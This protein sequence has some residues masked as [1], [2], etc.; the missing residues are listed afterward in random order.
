MSAPT[1]MGST[2]NIRIFQTA[3]H[4]CGYYPD[5]L[6]RDLVL[7][8]AD[9]ALAGIYG[10]ALAM[11]FRRSGAHVYRPACLGCSACRPVRIPVARFIPDRSQRRCLKR[12]SDLQLSVQPAA[13]SEENFALYRRYL[14]SRHAGGGMDQPQASDFDAFLA[15]AW[16]PTRFLE[17]RLGAQLLAVAVTDVLPNA[18]SAVYT[19]FEPEQAGRSLGTFAILSQIEQARREGRAHLYL[20]FWLDGHPKMHYKRNFQPLETLVGKD[21]YPLGTP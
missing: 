18:L 11:G 16:S 4:R 10:N 5:R 20:G 15:C 8:P 7:D 1:G 9:P 13:R 17:F 19:F 14:D 6:A 21:W 2:H 3:E 12:N